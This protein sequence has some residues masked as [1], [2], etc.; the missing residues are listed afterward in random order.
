MSRGSFD[1]LDS[2]AQ[3]FEARGLLLAGWLHFLAFDLLLGAW[4][5]RT[6]AREGM[7][8]W[9]IMTALGLTF[10]FGP[11]GYLLFLGQRAAVRTGRAH[12]TTGPGLLAQLRA[13]IATWSRRC[14]ASAPSCC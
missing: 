8:H 9:T 10:M 4:I 3:L 6:A 1:T 13:K 12:P 11:A 14:S 2:L 5:A 7:G